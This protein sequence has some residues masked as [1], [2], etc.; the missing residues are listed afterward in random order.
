L[1]PDFRVAAFRASGF[2]ASGFRAVVF[3]VLPTARTFFL[4]GRFAA[5]LSLDAGFGSS[6]FSTT[7]FSAPWDFGRLLCQTIP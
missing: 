3:L 5:R 4:A 1:A 6:V 7:V 2:R